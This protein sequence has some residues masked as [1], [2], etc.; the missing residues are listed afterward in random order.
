MAIHCESGSE[1]HCPYAFIASSGLPRQSL[2]FL[3]RNDKVLFTP[4]NSRP[5]HREGVSQ[6]GSTVNQKPNRQT[7]PHPS[8]HDGLPRPSL[9]LFPRNDKVCCH[10]EPLAGVAIHCEPASEETNPVRAPSRHDGLPRRPV[11]L[12][13][14][15]KSVL[16]SRGLKPRDDPLGTTKR[17]DKSTASPE[18]R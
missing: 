3:P 1:P 5:C 2:A 10:R 17:R 18:T 16:S 14:M 9:A 4:I 15:T 7:R 12:L 13:A 6:W 8:R 11:V